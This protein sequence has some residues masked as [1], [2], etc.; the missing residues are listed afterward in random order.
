MEMKA[1]HFSTEP[2]RG[3][4]SGNLAYPKFIL[5]NLGN[6]LVWHLALNVEKI[7]YRFVKDWGKR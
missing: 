4:K 6:F 2:V 5:P 1:Q 7:Y 3:L